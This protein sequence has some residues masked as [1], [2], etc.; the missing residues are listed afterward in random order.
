MTASRPK[1]CKYG[2]TS[3]WVG[4][5]LRLNKKNQPSERAKSSKA[6][7]NLLY[8]A[9][10]LA[11]VLLGISYLVSLIAPTLSKAVGLGGAQSYY[12]L[13]VALFVV[14]LVVLPLKLLITLI[15]LVK[16]TCEQGYAHL[17]VL[18]TLK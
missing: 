7:S 11:L 3:F 16:E 12:Y 4:L 2:I 15:N 13:T 10:I 1:Y 17:Q 8:M 14:I 9:P 5:K 18:E 6:I